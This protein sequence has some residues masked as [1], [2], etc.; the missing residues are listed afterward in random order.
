MKIK[1]Q[2]ADQTYMLKNDLRRKGRYRLQV[3]GKEVIFDASTP[4]EASKTMKDYLD[5]TTTSGPI[6]NLNL[7]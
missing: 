5:L 4:V 1:I 3:P 6:G 2:V 7:I